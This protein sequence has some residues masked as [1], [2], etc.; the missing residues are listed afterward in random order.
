MVFYE[1]SYL[2]HIAETLRRDM[3]LVGMESFS[4][5]HLRRFSVLCSL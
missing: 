1:Q 3:R 4:Q 2:L 5:N